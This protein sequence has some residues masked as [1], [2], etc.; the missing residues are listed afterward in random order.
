MDD[1]GER[2]AKLV[3]VAHE[4]DAVLDVRQLLT[5]R[6]DAR[7]AALGL[8]HEVVQVGTEQV[9]T[10]I[11]NAARSFVLSAKPATMNELPNPSWWLVLL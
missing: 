5:E 3:L 8:Y 9:D 6:D 7:Q 10:G 1:L 2:H 4:F 11:G